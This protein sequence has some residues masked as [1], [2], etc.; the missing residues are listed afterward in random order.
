MKMWFLKST[1]PTDDGSL[2]V[3]CVANNIPYINIEAQHGHTEKQRAMLRVC[4]KSFWRGIDVNFQ[5]Y[6][7]VELLSEGSS[8]G[9][10]KCW[11][12]DSVS[13]CQLPSAHCLLSP[14]LKKN[15][16]K[17]AG[18]LLSVLFFLKWIT[19]RY[20]CSSSKLTAHSY[21]SIISQPSSTLLF[22]E[23]PHWYYYQQQVWFTKARC[24]HPAFIYS[25]AQ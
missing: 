14:L 10:V 24:S 8:T 6:E 22:L 17:F 4:V 25:I 2:S 3:Y 19:K 21:K 5:L 9:N 20:L 1:T 18:P 16:Q 15:P 11:F 12:T 13:N 7:S 23:R